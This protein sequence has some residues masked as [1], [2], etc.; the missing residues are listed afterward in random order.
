MGAYIAACVVSESRR[1]ELT[2]HHMR[3]NK[4]YILGPQ[5]TYQVRAECNVKNYLADDL[6]TYDTKL[7]TKRLQRINNVD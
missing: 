3:K 7:N 5:S 6:H 2:F 1:R 4:L